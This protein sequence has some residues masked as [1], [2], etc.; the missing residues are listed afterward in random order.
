MSWHFAKLTWGGK[1]K[2]I[3]QSPCGPGWWKSVTSSS[4]FT[5][6]TTLV[7]AL[8]FSAPA[9]ALRV[10][11]MKQSY[12]CFC[13]LCQQSLMERC[14]SDSVPV[15][16]SFSDRSL[17]G[18]LSNCA[19]PSTALM[20]H[21]SLLPPPTKAKTSTQ[22]GEAVYLGWVVGSLLP[23]SGLFWTVFPWSLS[24]HQ[25]IGITVARYWQND[26]SE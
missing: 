11:V 25:D 9:A 19:W 17:R 10:S 6:K 18:L 5:H 24:F 22:H 12:C 23:Y 3:P 2:A 1:Q 16:S 4:L 8:N 13:S 7:F 15:C 26:V 20:G 14:V 21:T